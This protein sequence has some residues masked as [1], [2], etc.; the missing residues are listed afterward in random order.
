MGTLYSANFTD[1]VTFVLGIEQGYS[2]DAGGTNFGITQALC[3]V[4]FPGTNVKDLSCNNAIYVYHEEFWIPLRLERIAQT[5]YL[6]AEKI[7]QWAVN[8][9]VSMAVKSTQQCL[10]ALPEDYKVLVDGILGSQTISAIL[11]YVG[12][13]KELILGKMINATQCVFYMSLNRP[14]DIEGWINK[15]IH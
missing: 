13:G 10:N 5:S 7:F 1:A 9:G 8:A 6:I 3:N 11:D 15:R 12:K 14:Q 4:Y 2:T